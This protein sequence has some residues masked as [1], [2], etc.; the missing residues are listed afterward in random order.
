MRTIGEDFITQLESGY[1]TPFTLF[2]FTDGDDWHRY[3]NFDVSI[4]TTVV[5]GAGAYTY[6]SIGYT[7]ESMYYSVG[8]IVDEANIHIDNVNQVMTLFFGGNNIQGQQANIWVGVMDINGIVLDV[9]NLFNGEI[10]SFQL[11]QGKLT[12]K[13][14]SYFSK[15]SHKSVSRHG[16]LCRWRVFKGIECQYVGAETVCDRTYKKCGDVYSNT[17][18]F[19]GFRWLPDLE[20]KV[21]WWGPTPTEYG[22]E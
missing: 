6:D 8:N 15:W 12:L 20:D 14:G 3:T 21:I 10:D 2:E 5:S 16:S 7:I 9:L 13:L 1:L 17:A 11:D 4:T 22:T 18:N 19:G